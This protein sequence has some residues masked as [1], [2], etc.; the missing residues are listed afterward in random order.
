M[1]CS[2]MS[3]SA[4]KTAYDAPWQQGYHPACRAA[5][6]QLERQHEARTQPKHAPARCQRCRCL[7]GEYMACHRA[8]D[9]R[10]ACQG[11]ACGVLNEQSRKL[12]Q[13]TRIKTQSIN[14]IKHS[15]T[16]RRGTKS[17]A[18][19]EYSTC[20]GPRGALLASWEDSGNQHALSLGVASAESVQHSCCRC[21]LS[22]AAGLQSRPQQRLQAFNLLRRRCLRPRGRE[23]R[24]CCSSESSQ[25]ARSA[26]AEQTLCRP[27]AVASWP[28]S[29]PPEP[30]A[31]LQAA[32]PR[33][34]APGA[35]DAH[36][37]CRWTPHT[38]NRVTR[39]GSHLCA[40]SWRGNAA[41]EQ[42]QRKEGI[43][44]TTSE[45]R[46]LVADPVLLPLL[47]L[48]RRKAG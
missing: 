4:W 14:N 18:S 3:T 44:R 17:T 29:A 9:T 35:H 41:G 16:T 10:A 24:V 19:H 34:G 22:W 48:E 1:A 31:C 33:T 39:R 15:M 23:V 32:P 2:M 42:R 12:L 25:I 28:P 30:A 20:T 38:V 5:P 26:P 36:S 40:N 21:T 27:P 6:Q 7:H 13:L 8:Q 11:L 43:Q 45:Q 46:C 47:L 37:A